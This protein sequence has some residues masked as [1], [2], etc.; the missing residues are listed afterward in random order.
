MWKGDWKWNGASTV[1]NGVNHCV[2]VGDWM[3]H[4]SLQTAEMGEATYKGWSPVSHP[5]Q[6]PPVRKKPR[7]LPPRAGASCPGDESIL[8]ESF[9][10]I[11]SGY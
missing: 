9:V 2:L 8:T 5:R 3:P 10:I 6:L 1:W 4:G 7:V 11:F